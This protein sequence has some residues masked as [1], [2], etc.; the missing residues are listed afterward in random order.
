[1]KKVIDG[2]LY[3]TETAREIGAWTNHERGFGFVSQTLYRT[4][5]GK[6]FIH[7]E[8]GARTQYAD[9]CGNN[10][11][12]EGERI[13]P[14]TAGSARKW[15]EEYLSA[16]QYAA[17][18]GEPDEAGDD[19]E[20][21]NITVPADVKKKLEKLRAETGKSISQIIVDLIN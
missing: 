4:K 10:V 14:M 20:A 2:A 18:F 16:T 15:A 19:K 9:N 12:A 1:M 6:Y 8:G 5:S 11:W 3:N 17:E 21:L 7:G 13:E